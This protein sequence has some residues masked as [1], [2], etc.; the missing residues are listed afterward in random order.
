[1]F[2]CKRI[3]SIVSRHPPISDASPECASQSA[4]CGPSPAAAI[5]KSARAACFPSP[6]SINRDLPG[7]IRFGRHVHDGSGGAR[8]S[9]PPHSASRRMMTRGGPKPV[10]IGRRVEG[11]RVF[12][13]S[14]TKWR[15]TFREAIVSCGETILWRAWEATGQGERRRLRSFWSASNRRL[16]LIPLASFNGVS[17][18]FFF[19]ACKLVLLW[20]LRI[21]DSEL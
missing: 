10:T 13:L 7:G 3:C 12:S 8:A 17:R 9:R 20:S 16:P 15:T 6:A 5:T 11:G 18:R 4:E 2:A 21:W 14:S 19:A 1:V